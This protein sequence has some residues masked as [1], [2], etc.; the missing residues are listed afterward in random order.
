MERQ[1]HATIDWELDD[2]SPSPESAEQ[3]LEQTGG[4]QNEGQVDSVESPSPSTVLPSQQIPPSPL[5]DQ[6]SHP[7]NWPQHDMHQR[8]GIV[9]SHN[10]SCILRSHNL[11]SSHLYS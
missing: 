11:I 8:F 2:T 5:W 6:E 9:S 10:F 7:D 4:Y 3:D 1:G